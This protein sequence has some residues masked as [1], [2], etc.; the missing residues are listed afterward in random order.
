M[1]SIGGAGM[2]VRHP[3][4]AGLVDFDITELMTFLK[5]HVNV[6]GAETGLVTP[7]GEVALIDVDGNELDVDDAIMNSALAT[8][9]PTPSEPDPL[10]DLVTI[11]SGNGTVAQKLVGLRVWAVAEKARRDRIG[12][13]PRRFRG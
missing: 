8:F 3:L 10:D 7:D 2:G 13:P 9:V 6:A 5:S 1:D 11:L 4:P 12:R